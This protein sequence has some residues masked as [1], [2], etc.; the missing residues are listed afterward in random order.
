[1]QTAGYGTALK[2]LFEFDDKNP[3]NDPPLRRTELVSLFNTLDRVSHSLKNIKTFRQAVEG[4]ATSARLLAE[5]TANFSVRSSVNANSPD[6]KKVQ[7][8]EDDGYPDFS[9]R[10]DPDMSLSEMF[11][12]EFYLILRVFRFVFARWIEMPK[13]M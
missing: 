10:T 2:I 1:M 6:E 9:R 5:P 4:D 11:W 8:E 13:K 7:S 3:K 12:D